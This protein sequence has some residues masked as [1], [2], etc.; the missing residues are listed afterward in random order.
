MK[1]DYE[2]C[3]GCGEE[4]LVGGVH[5]CAK[6][7]TSVFYM[8]SCRRCGVHLPFYDQDIRDWWADVH[9]ERAEHVV[10]RTEEPR[11]QRVRP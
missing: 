5:V 10:S 3:Q 6:P 11:E 9:E 8:A 4:V 1:W 2:I 7:A